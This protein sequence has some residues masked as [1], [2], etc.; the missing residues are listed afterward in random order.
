MTAVVVAATAVQAVAATDFLSASHASSEAF[1]TATLLK[2]LP[3]NALISGEKG[4]GKRK[5]AQVILPGA[6]A[7][8]ASEFDNV[9]NALESN[10]ELVLTHIEAC[11]NH[12][13][14]LERITQTSTRVVATSSAEYLPD[15]VKEFFSVKIVLPPLCER[16]E[17][18]ELLSR[19]FLQEADA[20]FGIAAGAS[21]IPS[22]PDLTE[23]A[24][25]LRRQIFFERLMGSIGEEEVMQVMERFLSNRLGS[26]NDY[27]KFL[28]LYEAPLIR[29]GLQRFKSQLQ[30]SERLGLNR[31]TLRKKIAENETYIK[32]EN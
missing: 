10:N 2:T 31:N 28:H 25:S 16:F 27:R 8:D 14:L 26:H 29:S 1:R 24:Y 13:K 5:L 11:P 20:L 12:T 30:L 3:V 23:N 7:M 17:D 9:L 19:Y 15:T 6:V 21:M 18:V 32:E 22:Q 4:C